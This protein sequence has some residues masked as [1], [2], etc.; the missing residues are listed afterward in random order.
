[1]KEKFCKG[2]IFIS[3]FLTGLDM[4]YKRE[5]CGILPKKCRVAPFPLDMQTSPLR[6]VASLIPLGRKFSLI[7]F[8]RNSRSFHPDGILSCRR[9]T[10]PG[11]LTSGILSD[12]CE[13]LTAGILSDRRPTFSGYLTAGIL[14]YLRSTF[15]GYFVSSACHRMGE[16]DDS[17]SSGRHVQILR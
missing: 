12:R 5:H 14:S 15:S 11:Y 7:P 8:R 3:S 16:E 4:R 10:F 9:P 13:Y 2:I 1:M 17:T 6:H